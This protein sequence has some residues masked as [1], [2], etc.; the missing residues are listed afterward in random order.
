MLL[1]I[2]IT[3]K[4]AKNGFE[5]LHVIQERLSDVGVPMYQLLL[6]DYIMQEMD[7]PEFTIFLGNLMEQEGLKMP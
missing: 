4:T 5:A 1:E 6:V 3:S 7:G 2:G